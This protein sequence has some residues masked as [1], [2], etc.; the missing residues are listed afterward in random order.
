MIINQNGQ[1]LTLKC[2]ACQVEQVAD[3][4]WGSL[5]DQLPEWRQLIYH[6]QHAILCPSCNQNLRH[7]IRQA[8]QGLAVLLAA[9]CAIGSIKDQKG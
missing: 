7:V 6:P 9:W 4:S 5:E 1:E 8:Q 3:M 2:D